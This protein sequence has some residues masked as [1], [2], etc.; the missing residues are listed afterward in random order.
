MLI[1]FDSFL[2]SLFF[3]LLLFFLPLKKPKGSS[4]L[5]DS[6]KVLLT[7]ALVIE[8]DSCEIHF[9]GVDLFFKLFYEPKC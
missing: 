5:L 2:Q 1:T 4:V 9:E 8:C 3:R 7:F 6:L